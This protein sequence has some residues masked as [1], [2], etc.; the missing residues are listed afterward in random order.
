MN[1]YKK[2][3]A[4]DATA[5]K[6]GEKTVAFT[7][8]KGKFVGAR[9]LLQHDEGA[10]TAWGLGWIGGRVTSADNG[11]LSICMMFDVWPIEWTLHIG[12]KCLQKYLI[13]EMV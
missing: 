4:A 6:K 11:L 8:E 13:Q 3:K 5:I 1:T 9:S 12:S 2:S 7:M 10:A